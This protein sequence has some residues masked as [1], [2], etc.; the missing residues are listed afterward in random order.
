MAAADLSWAKMRAATNLPS[1]QFT[2]V[3]ARY[4]ELVNAAS[5]ASAS[6]LSAPIARIIQGLPEANVTKGLFFD[7]THKV[8][9]IAAQAGDTV[10]QHQ[11]QRNTNNWIATLDTNC[12]GAY[13]VPPF[14]SRWRIYTNACA[15]A[16]APVRVEDNVIG[17][18]WQ[19][20]GR[21]SAMVEQFRTSLTNY[22]GPLAK[23]AVGTAGT[24]ALDASQQL[25]SRFVSS[26][27]QRVREKFQ[28]LAAQRNWSLDAVTNARTWFE[29][30]ERDAAAGKGIGSQAPNLAGMGGLIGQS[31]QDVLRAIDTSVHGKL[32]FPVLLSG[33]PKRPMRLQDL[34]DLR[35]LLAGLGRD[36]E[37]PVWKSDTSGSVGA[38]QQNCERYAPLVSLFAKDDGSPAEWEILFVGSRQGTDEYR[39][40]S[41]YRYAQVS[42]AGTKTLPDLSGVEAGKAESAGKGSVDRG[43]TISF[44]KSDTATDSATTPVKLAPWGLPWLI[45]DNKDGRLE[46]GSGWR[47]RVRLVDQQQNL[48]GDAVFEVRPVNA[49]QP[50]PK[51]EAWSK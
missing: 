33:D 4:M 29:R 46:D 37:Q 42:L 10:R 36:L 23:E 2:G 13:A 12:F 18:G 34:S 8:Q 22:N 1:K 20:F 24:I 50:L 14:Q 5:E 15:L 40:V 48:S 31:K 43:V 11:V 38:L 7:L 6:A 39:I 26:Y 30:V 44:Q 41:V 45:R 3:G 47:V 25:E 21:L 49:T 28:E 19:Q 16:T 27:L 35:G 32:G 9:E 17:D 51:Y